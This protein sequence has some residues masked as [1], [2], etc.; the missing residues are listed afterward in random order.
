MENVTDILPDLNVLLLY[1]ISLLCVDTHTQPP[2]TDR[3]IIILIYSK[4][5]KMLTTTT[6]RD[7]EGVMGV[8]IF[9]FYFEK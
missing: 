4:R 8:I 6:E 1:A 2:Y 9:I 7:D 3:I 5:L